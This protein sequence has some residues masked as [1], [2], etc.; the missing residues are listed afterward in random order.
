MSEKVVKVKIDSVRHP[1]YGEIGKVKVEDDGRVKVGR[2]P[3]VS[4]DMF[5]VELIDC[6]H[7]TRSCFVTFSDVELLKQ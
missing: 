5:E 1:H 4:S 2:L 3:G 7:G 6:P